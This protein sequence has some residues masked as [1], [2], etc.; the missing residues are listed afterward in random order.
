VYPSLWGT[1]R[2]YLK[3]NLLENL[4]SVHL[5]WCPLV[6]DLAGHLP[7]VMVTIFLFRGGGERTWGEC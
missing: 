5:P 1:V 4:F 2:V 3:G 6:E 7:T